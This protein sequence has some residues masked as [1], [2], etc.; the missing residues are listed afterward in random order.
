M[1]ARAGVQPATFALGVCPGPCKTM[2]S[3]ATEY[4]KYTYK[5]WRF[6]IVYERGVAGGRRDNEYKVSQS[7]VPYSRRGRLKILPR[8]DDGRGLRLDSEASN[9]SSKSQM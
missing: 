4:S 2:L 6:V 8:G 9:A 5:H 1:V 7:R 3:S